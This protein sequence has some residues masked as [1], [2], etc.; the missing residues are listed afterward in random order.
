MNAARSINSAGLF[1]GGPQLA[2]PWWLLRLIEQAN[3]EEQRNADLLT[4]LSRDSASDKPAKQEARRANRY[5][6]RERELAEV[7]AAYR[8]QRMAA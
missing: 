1:V 7:R 3:S 8:A 2:Q 5:K 6:R 4:A